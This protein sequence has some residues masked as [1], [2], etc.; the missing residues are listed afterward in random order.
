MKQVTGN[1]AVQSEVLTPRTEF[2][3]P[4]S[5]AVI[6]TYNDLPVLHYRP[7]ATGETPEIFDADY[8]IIDGQTGIKEIFSARP[9]PSV[10]TT[11]K[12]TIRRLQNPG[13]MDWWRDFLDGI[14]G[15]RDPFLMPTWFHDLVLFE[16]PTPGSSQMIVTAPDYAA[17]YWPFETYKR[18]QLETEAGLVWRKV[19]GVTDNIDGTTTLDFDTPLGATAE[20]VAILKVS[21]LNLTR[22][23]TDTVTLT[24][25]RIRTSI[26]LSTRTV[27]Q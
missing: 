14:H 21:F 10:G 27:D 22:L 3:R 19:V 2:K 25:E 7:V 1:I 6:Q 17:L 23:A 26:E 8:E 11:R 9:H 4:G 15:M 12:W 20:E 24:H 5:T 13:E 16:T 18:L